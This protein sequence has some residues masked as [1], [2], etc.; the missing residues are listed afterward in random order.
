MK[1]HAGSCLCGRVKYHV[2]GEFE[3]FYLCH[4]QHCQKATGAAHAANLFSTSARLTWQS[5]EDQVTGFTLAGTRHS[6]NFCQQCG[7]P[8]PRLQPEGLLMVPAGSL[9]SP[10]TLSPQAHL[11]TASQA[12]WEKQLETLPK[13]AAL[14]D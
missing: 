14:P 7:S 13:F 4:C 11:F 12:A 9:D 8:L 2:H 1:Q 3:S 5:G 10:L 6:R